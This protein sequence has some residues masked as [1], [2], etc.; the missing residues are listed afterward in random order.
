VLIGL[1]R[2]YLV[3]LKDAKGRKGLD[4]LRCQSKLLASKKR[5]L[6]RLR[7]FSFSNGTGRQGP[8]GGQA[9]RAHRRTIVGI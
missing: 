8:S 6:P 2:R 3:F 7:G 5:Q 4:R 1:T 9:Q